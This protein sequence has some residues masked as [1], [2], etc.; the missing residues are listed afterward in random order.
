[1]INPNVDIYQSIPLIYPAQSKMYFFCRDAVC[2]FVLENGAAPLHPFRLFDY[3]LGDRVDRD[4]IR[5]ANNNIVMHVDE[6]W[7]FG[8]EL[9]DGV[10]AEVSLAHERGKPVKYFSIAT[11]SAEIRELSV[12]DL[13]F[14]PELLALAGGD[15]DGLRAVASG[16]KRI[17]EVLMSF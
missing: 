1:M 12:A 3:F 2:Q 17:A 4:F 10:L 11:R 14:E 16:V 13:H 15:E 7:V 9:A 8:E 5:R 6:V